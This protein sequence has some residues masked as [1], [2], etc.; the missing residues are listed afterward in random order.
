MNAG[1]W[2]CMSSQDVVDFVRYQVS[3][4]K[5]LTEIGEMIC[6]HCLAPDTASGDYIGCDNMTVLIIA[7]THGRSKKKWYSWIAGRV[8]NKYGYDTPSTFPSIY[9]ES[10]LRA[11]RAKKEN[12][13]KHNRALEERR[14]AEHKASTS[15]PSSTQAQAGGDVSETLGLES[16]DLTRNLKEGLTGY[17]KEIPEEHS[18]SLGLVETGRVSGGFWLRLHKA[19]K[20][21]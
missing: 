4:G 9:S 5:E 2:D 16:P 6:D 20:L 19:L 7:I 13:D 12:Y 18:S 10:R 15:T 21:V 8:K 1:I 17:E 11:F 14:A 3:K